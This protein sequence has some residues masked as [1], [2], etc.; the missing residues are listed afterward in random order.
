MGIM[1]KLILIAGALAAE[2]SPSQEGSEDYLIIRR[3]YYYRPYRVIRHYGY[4]HHRYLPE[5]SEK[6]QLWFRSAFRKVWRHRRLAVAACILAWRNRR[7]LMR[8]ARRFRR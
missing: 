2:P 1:N 3:H 7:R 4:F 6:T 5:Q 8:L